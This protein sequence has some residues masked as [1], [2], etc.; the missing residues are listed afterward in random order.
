MTKGE[1][2]ENS[3]KLW[4]ISK[5]KSLVSFRKKTSIISRISK[6]LAQDNDFPAF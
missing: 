2:S 5:I 6:F 3:L 1:E 4:L